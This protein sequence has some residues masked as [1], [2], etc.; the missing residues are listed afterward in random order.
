MGCPICPPDADNDNVDRL[1]PE[2]VHDANALSD[3]MAGAAAGARIGY[4]IG[5]LARDRYRGLSQLPDAQCRELGI[6]ADYALRLA[7]AGWAHLV[8]R[9]L[10]EERFLYLL[11]VRPRRRRDRAEAMPSLPV[12]ILAEAA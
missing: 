3:F 4:H 7:E 10:G 1:L 11:V 5:A 8:Q 12:I 2:I 6:L 9:R